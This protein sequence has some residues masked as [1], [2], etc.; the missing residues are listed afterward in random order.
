MVPG[1]GLT[2]VGEDREWFWFVDRSG[3][4]RGEGKEHALGTVMTTEAS[5]A[6]WLADADA[7][8]SRD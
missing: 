2:V 1:Y 7:E 5:A 6:H 8:D 3:R 4:Y